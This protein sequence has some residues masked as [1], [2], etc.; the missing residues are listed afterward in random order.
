MVFDPDGRL[1][2][3]AVQSSIVSEPGPQP[4]CGYYLEDGRAVDV[5]M[6]G[7][8]FDYAWGIELALFSGSGGTLTLTVDGVGQEVEVP[9]GLSSPQLSHVGPVTEVE[10]RIDGPNASA[11]L[12]GVRAGELVARAG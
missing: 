4:D 2:P 3:G 10:V 7:G 11:C 1:A 8:L 5:P 9:S 12:T 6:T